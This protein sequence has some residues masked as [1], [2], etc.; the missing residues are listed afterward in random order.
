MNVTNNLKLPQYTE[1]DI[2]DL[3]DIN[4]AYDSIDKAYKEVIDF[5]NEIPKTNATAEVID[6][7]GGKETL[8]ERLNEF[9]EQL[10]SIVPQIDGFVS[11][12]LYEH[13]VVDGDWTNA[14]KTALNN[15]KNVLLPKGVYNISDTIVLGYYQAL[16]GV[17]RELTKINGNF[18]GKPVIKMYGKYVK[19]SSLSITRSGNIS[20][21]AND[22]GIQCGNGTEFLGQSII[23]EV[24]IVNQ[25][26]GIYASP[27]TNVYSCTFRDIWINGYKHSAIF[28]EP[29][30]STG[31]IFDNIY[32]TNWDNW[33]NKTKHNALFGMFLKNYS[34]CC[35]RQLNIEHC[36]LNNALYLNS[37]DTVQIE[38]IH[39]EGYEQRGEYNGVICVDTSNVNINTVTLVYSSTE[40][41]RNTLRSANIDW[42][43][44]KVNNGSVYCNTVFNRDNYNLMGING[45]IIKNGTTALAYNVT[46]SNYK[47]NVNFTVK[48]RINK[49]NLFNNLSQFSAKSTERTHQIK[50]V[51]GNVYYDIN[52]NMVI[53]HFKKSIPTSGRWYKGDRITN[54]NNKYADYLC[55]TGGSFPNTTLEGLC[56]GTQWQSQIQLTS[57]KGLKV[58]DRIQITGSDITNTITELWEGGATISPVININANNAS[59]VLLNPIFK[60]IGLI[61]T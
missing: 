12:K 61:E 19:L 20:S 50:E 36:N 40:V 44:F 53:N 34:E 18:N 56:T 32:T 39:I 47:D 10:D 13:L 31:C 8:G 37:C 4:K 38:T 16:K 46:Q 21:N 23:E 48:N 41:D 22:S 55:V 35:I 58:G 5:K 1:E 51:D 59:I 11:V 15:H 26:K 25:N 43:I 17:G 49:E 29:Y 42:N 3:Q 54:I 2:F 33:E 60:G 6:A 14:I 30:G 52:S 9:D 45:S 7:R 57:I 28:L 24:E 27:T